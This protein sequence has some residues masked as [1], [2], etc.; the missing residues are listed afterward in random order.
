MEQERPPHEVAKEKIE[1]ILRELI[2]QESKG[3]EFLTDYVILAAAHVETPGENRGTTS[4]RRLM[5]DGQ[6]PHNTLGLLKNEQVNFEMHMFHHFG[7][8]HD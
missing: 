1:D 8:D 4:Y 3:E 6:S 2:Q 7:H 5:R